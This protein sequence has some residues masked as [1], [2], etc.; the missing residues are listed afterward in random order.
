MTQNRTVRDMMVQED[1]GWLEN[2]SVHEVDGKLMLGSEHSDLP[3]NVSHILHEQE[4][5]S[6]WLMGFALGNSF[7]V[8]YF[9][10]QKWFEFSF[11]GTRAVMIVR[12]EEGLN[13]SLKPTLL[14]PPLITT[15][16]TE[17]D[18]DLL[19][20]AALIINVNAKDTMKKN[21]LNANM[22]VALALADKEHGLKAKPLTITDLINPAFYERFG[23][24]PEVEQKIYYIRDV[25]RKGVKTE[26]EDLN[27]SRSILY[28]DHKKEPVSRDEY[29]FLSELSMG[30]FLIEDKVDQAPASVSGTGSNPVPPSNP[31]E[32]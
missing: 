29:R 20:K 12:R 18:R 16:L 8:P 32:C 5:V 21:N 3:F 13:G 26:I 11:N 2:L 31:L 6:K 24:I 1:L 7:G 9:P 28:R 22:E 10:M 30:E 4:F 14:V 17:E 27:K 23:I 25:I 15:T 19:R